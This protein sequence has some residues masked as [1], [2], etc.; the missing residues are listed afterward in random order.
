MTPTGPRTWQVKKADFP[1]DVFIRAKNLEAC[2]AVVSDVQVVKDGTLVGQFP[3]TVSSDHEGRTKSYEI[4]KPAQQQR[5]KPPCDLTQT[6]T[7]WFGSDPP[8]HA[9]YAIIVTSAKG[10][11][12]ST[13]IGVPT[14]D[15]GIANLTFQYR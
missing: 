6:I 13:S 15:P 5:Q 10:D 14:I 1:I 7:G 8:D 4:R 9:S 12:F 3:V 11:E 2:D